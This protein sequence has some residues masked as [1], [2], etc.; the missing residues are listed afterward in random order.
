MPREWQQKRYKQFLMPDAVY[1]QC[2]WAVRDLYR[3]EQRIEELEKRAAGVYGAR[4]FSDR[5]VR[6]GKGFSDDGAADEAE[7]QNLKRR[8]ATI[9]E[10]LDTVPE[11]YRE[12]ILDNI[13]LRTPSKAQP[14]KMWKYWKQR[15][16]YDLAKKFAMI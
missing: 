7:L 8:A 9:R 6:Y 10:V 1:L 3:M 15:F 16:L 12:N 14:G 2:L 11:E 5:R 4:S 13:I